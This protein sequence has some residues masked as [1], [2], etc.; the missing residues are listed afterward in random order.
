VAAQSTPPYLR[1]RIEVLRK[2]REQE[3]RVAENMKRIRY[4]IAV[5]SGKGGVGKSFVTASL[6]FALANMGKQVGVLDADIHGPSIPKMM[7]VEGKYP[8]AVAPDRIKPVTAPLGVKV[9]SI[10]LMLPD[11]R[12]PVIWRGPVKTSFIRELLAY[13]EWGELDYLLIDLPP[14]TGDEQLTIAQLIKQL[15]GFIVVTIPSEVSKY[16][17]VKAIS[18]AQ[19]L[20][21]RILGLVENMSYFVCPDGSKHYIFGKGVGDDIAREY[22]IPLLGR[23]PL[24]PRISRANDEGVPFFMKYP[25]SPA[26]RELVRIAEKLVDI[27]EG[28]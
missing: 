1:A 2:I 4:K 20:N 26:A 13:T 14:G 22:G 8:E 18:F 10:A 16:V 17:V 7:G 3:Q 11:E 28:G 19:K 24:D 15:S 25:D 5:L 6:A 21:T 12:T 23:I 9:M 27:V